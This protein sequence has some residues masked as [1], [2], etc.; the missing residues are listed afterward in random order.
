M[1]EKL[2][3]ARSELSY[4]TKHGVFCSDSS[5]QQ[6]S[7]IVRIKELILILYS[8]VISL[9]GIWYAQYMRIR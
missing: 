8:K 9:L 6:I 2:E 4:Y 1:K 7:A 5:A 3:W